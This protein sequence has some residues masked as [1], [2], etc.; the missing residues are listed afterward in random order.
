MNSVSLTFEST[1]T[2]SEGETEKRTLNLFIKNA[3][4][5]KQTQQK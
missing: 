4:Q 5:N 2:A 1:F 3:K